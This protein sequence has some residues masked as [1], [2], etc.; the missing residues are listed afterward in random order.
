M[1]DPPASRRVDLLDDE[2][3]KDDTGRC[4]IGYCVGR[5]RGAEMLAECAQL[6]LADPVDEEEDQVAAPARHTEAAHHA[7]LVS[8]RARRYAPRRASTSRSYSRRSRRLAS[9]TR[10]APGRGVRV[11]VCRQRDPRPEG[12]SG[13]VATLLGR[14]AQPGVVSPCDP[15][16]APATSGDDDRERAGDRGR[17][18][19]VQLGNPF[20]SACKTRVVLGIA[21]LSSVPRAPGCPLVPRRTCHWNRAVSRLGAGAFGGRLRVA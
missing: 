5:M 15:A 1:I 21:R 3:P 9:A 14:C 16:V 2:V 19:D 17:T 6:L 7:T 18:G 13:R 20:G 11:A 4:I 10:A 12:G 8:R